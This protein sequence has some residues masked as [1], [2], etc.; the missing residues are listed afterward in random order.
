MQVAVN[1]RG[2]R[3]R[4]WVVRPA[5][6]VHAAAIRSVALVAILAFTA[7]SAGRPP[8][9]PGVIPEPQPLTVTEEQYGHQILDQLSEQYPLDYNNPRTNEVLDVVDRLTKAAKADRDPW[10]VYVF[11]DAKFKNAAATRGNHVFIWSAMLDATHT[12]AELAAVLAHEISHVLARHTDPDPN[13]ELKKLLIGVGSMAAGIAVAH[14]TGSYSMASDLGNITSSVT[15]EL[16]SG[17]LV[18]PYSRD[19]EFE[20]DQIGMFMM[21]DAKFDPRAAID[22]WE[23]A[24]T[25]PSFSN[26]LAFFST[27]PPAGARLERL[28]ALLPAA[29]ARYRGEVPPGPVELP[30]AATKTLPP[31]PAAPPPAGAADSFEVDPSTVRG[32]TSSPGKQ[33]DAWI[34]VADKAVLFQSANTTAKKLGEFSVGARVRGRGINSDWVEID[35]PDHGFLRRDDVAAEP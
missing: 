20:A 4:R 7:C 11:R 8:V 29:L 2:N 26:G 24:E 12:E 27:H 6:A 16:G 18:Y 1:I 25:D 28:K 14:A 22:F 35:Q 17:V 3:T 32:R 5:R 10:H 15:Q 30:G 21:A 31:G 13:E 23:R 19:R 9:P 34:V 33:Q